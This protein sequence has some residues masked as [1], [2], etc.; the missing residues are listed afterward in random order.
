M[1]LRFR[2]QSSQLQP[3]LRFVCS[4]DRYNYGDLLFPIVSRWALMGFGAC[5]EKYI[6]EQYGL[7]RSDLSVFG[8][9]RSRSISDLYRDVED[10]DVVILA[11]GENLAQTWYVMHLTVLGE[12]GAKAAM[13]CREK[14]GLRFAEKVARWRFRGRQEFPYILAPEHF[15]R[16]VRVMYNSMGGWPLAHYAPADQTSIVRAMAKA[17]F[18]SIREE[19]SASIVKGLDEKIDVRVAPDCVF[20]LSD[21]VPKEELARK[22]SDETRKII[23]RAGEFLCFQCHPRYGA[24]NRE[25]IKRQ[26][27]DLAKRSGLNILLAPIGRIHSFHDDVF[28]GPLAAELGDRASMLPASAGIYDVAYALASGM[29]FCGTSLHGVITAL[30]YGVPFV[31]LQSEDPKL[32]NNVTS[33]GLGEVFPVTPGSAIADRGLSSLALPPRILAEHAERLRRAAHDNMKNLAECILS[34]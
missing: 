26:L 25:E 14:L 16:D 8:A 31:P 9:L 17:S 4:C 20:L 19:I 18:I 11:G 12:W 24:V 28:L 7:K 27:L 3:H 29:L 34:G 30:T 21:M 1:N 23:Q 5:R 6:C 10:G 33:W 15:H 2:S 13:F 32:S 22:A